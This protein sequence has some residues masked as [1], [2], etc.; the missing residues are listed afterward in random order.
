LY[1]HIILE[2]GNE[3]I[4][5]LDSLYFFLAFLNL[6]FHR[7]TETPVKIFHL[8]IY[9]AYDIWSLPEEDQNLHSESQL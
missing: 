6:S 7:S 8:H 9:L 2:G 1:P 5:Q 3:N 4:S